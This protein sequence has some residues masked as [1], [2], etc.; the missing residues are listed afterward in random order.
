MGYHEWKQTFTTRLGVVVGAFVAGMVLE[1]LRS[2]SAWGIVVVTFFV[3]LASAGLVVACDPL[4]ERLY[5]RVY[6]RRAS[7]WADF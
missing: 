2:Y 6:R 5:R 3:G 7:E 1:A 4:L